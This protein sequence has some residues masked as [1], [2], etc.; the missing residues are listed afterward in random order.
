[1]E[2]RAGSNVISSWWSKNTKIV[3]THKLNLLNW[4]LNVLGEGLLGICG[5]PKCM[6]VYTYLHWALKQKLRFVSFTVTYDQ[7]PLTFS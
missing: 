5:Y 3:R 4:R 1:M 2:I 7:L 6:L